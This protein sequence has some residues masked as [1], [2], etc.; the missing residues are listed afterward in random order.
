MRYT[1]LAPWP[2]YVNGDPG[3]HLRSRAGYLA[4]WVDP[5]QPAALR[6]LPFAAIPSS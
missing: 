6:R 5:K 4:I 2:R 3:G 1:I